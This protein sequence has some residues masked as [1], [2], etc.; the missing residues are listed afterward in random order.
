MGL[1]QSVRVGYEPI[2]TVNFELFVN[3]MFITGGTP[4]LSHPVRMLKMYNFTDQNV[5]L[6]YDGVTAVDIVAS[7]GAF[8]D[9]F[10]SNKS[11]SGGVLEV[12]SGS[13]IYV[14]GELAAPTLGNV[15]I[16]VIYASAN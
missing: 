2:R 1:V 3:G 5:F 6:S 12:P 14:K 7:K 15:Y 13:Y 9:D 4:A 16:V 8:V 11:E 10:S